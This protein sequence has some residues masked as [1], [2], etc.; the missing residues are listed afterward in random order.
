MRAL[1]WHND[2][3]WRYGLHATPT[4]SRLRSGAE[5][6]GGTH[7]AAAVGLAAIMNVY[8]IV[9]AGDDV[10]IPHNVYGPNADFGNWLAKD[11]GITA[12]FYDPLIGAGIADLIQPNTRL[13][14]IEAPGSVT[15]E[16]P[17]R[18]SR[19]PRRRAA[20]LPRSTTPFRPGP[21]SPFEHGVDISVQALTKYQSRRQRRADGG[22]DHRANARR[23][24]RS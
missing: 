20:S 7:A 19:R 2:N 16:V 10:L 21:R 15:M 12:R 11:F 9:K 1:V 18:R 17:D 24:M 3:Q 5:I 8:G 6:E 13:I 14:W 22:D 23:C 4:S